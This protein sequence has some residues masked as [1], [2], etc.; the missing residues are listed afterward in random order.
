MTKGMAILTTSIGICTMSSPLR[1]NI[2]TMVNNSAISV[3]GE[4]RG[5]NTV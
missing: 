1:L 4:M 3:M 2:N 5:M